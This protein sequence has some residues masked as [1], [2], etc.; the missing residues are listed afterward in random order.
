[1]KQ[2]P[3]SIV[4]ILLGLILAMFLL[5]EILFSR[6]GGISATIKFTGVG[7]GLLC[8][9]RP[10]LAPWILTVAFFTQDYL[11]KVA[12]YFGIPS[13][14]VLY[15]VMGVGYGVMLMAALGSL[16][17]IM[18]MPRI[19]W[20]VLVIYVFGASLSAVI[21]G[22]AQG[23]GGTVDAAY[24]AVATGLPAVMAA[25]IYLYLGEDLRKMQKLI[26][27]QFIMAVIWCVIAV[28]QV[29][30]GFTPIEW[31]Y[32]ETGLSPVASAQMLGAEMQGRDPRPFGLG[33]GVVSFNV[34]SCFALYGF[35]RA[36]KGISPEGRERRLLFTRTLFFLGGLLIAY[37]V[38]ESR[39]KSSITL[40]AL[41]PFIYFVYR[42]GK[43]TLAMYAAGASAFVW[44]VTKSE[45]LLGMLEKWNRP[46]VK[47]LGEDY[48]ILTFAE[49]L[50]SFENLKNPNNLSAFGVDQTTDIHDFFSLVLVKSGVVGLGAIICGGTAVLFVLHRWAARQ[51]KELQAFYTIL[52]TMFIPFTV[53][54]GLG[55]SGGFHV[56]PN[57]IRIWTLAGCLVVLGTRYSVSSRRRAEVRQPLQR[58]VGSGQVARGRA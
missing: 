40:V 52:L 41:S 19:P 43:L 14:H 5:P 51:P 55:G 13:R 12:V 47:Y 38:F 15:E 18:A 50:K 42:S 20:R 29:H 31:Y 33:S 27:L 2:N 58:P 32:A 34:V 48:S 57:N 25:L 6:T 23:S 56:T 21:F 24:T 49:R 8:A 4:I 35:W 45:W 36:F 16:I 28:F 3:L 17:T 37:A 54:L 22:V 9:I 30:V 7:L 39:L 11:K 26:D 46:V 53:L 10:S 44:M 1:M